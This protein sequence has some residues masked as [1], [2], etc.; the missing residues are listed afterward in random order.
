MSSQGDSVSDVTGFEPSITEPCLPAAKRGPGRPPKRTSTE[1]ALEKLI[2]PASEWC[3]TFNNYRTDD[4]DRLV[5]LFSS[6]GALFCFQRESAPDTGT[7]H[8]QGVVRFAKSLVPVQVFTVIDPEFKRIHWERCRS[9]EHSVRYCSKEDSRESDSQ[10]YSNVTVCP[11][12]EIYGWQVEV[13]KMIPSFTPRNIYWFYESTGGVGK[14]LLVRYLCLTMKAIVVSGK[15]TDIKHGV[16]SFYESSG[17]GP[18]LVIID[19]PR[20]SVGYVS[21]SGIEQVANGCFFSSK[22]ESK[23]CIID[24]PRMICFANEPPNVHKMSLDRWQIYHIHASQQKLILE[25]PLSH[26]VRSS[27]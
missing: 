13:T 15:D 12:P 14:S 3:F 1:V 8:L 6:S 5:Q 18:E 17:A 21:Y 7:P 27:F 10:P 24:Y 26:S 2:Q 9:W 22:Y 11:I 23:Q 20:S 16:L 25:P 4:P 19:C